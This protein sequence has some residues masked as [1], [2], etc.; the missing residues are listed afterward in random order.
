MK[1]RELMEGIDLLGGNAGP[2]TG[3]TGVCYDSRKV[4]PGCVFVAISG[5]AADGNR[6][7]PPWPW[8]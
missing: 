7:I 5:F 3:I 1:L 8:E 2:E 6:F 4:T